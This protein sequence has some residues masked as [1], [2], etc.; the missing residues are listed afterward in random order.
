M[1][2]LFASFGFAA[3]RLYDSPLFIY[4]GIAAGYAPS[5]C[6]L[7]IA[8]WEYA[9]L[10][11]KST[12]P[13]V[14]SVAFSGKIRKQPGREQHANTEGS[15]ILSALRC[16][17]N[18]GTGERYL[19]LTVFVLVGRVDIMLGVAALLSCTQAVTVY[20]AVREMGVH[21][22]EKTRGKTE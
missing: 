15:R 12:P 9:F 17:L 16:F 14:R 8:G 5:L 22:S 11:E 4:L 19:L 3:W 21:L 10:D 13:A 20:R 7:A 18:P 2:I 6:S 1:M